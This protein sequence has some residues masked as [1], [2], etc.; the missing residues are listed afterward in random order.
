MTSIQV[1]AQCMLAK[2]VFSL[3]LMQR[4]EKPPISWKDYWAVSE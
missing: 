1:A 3:Q 4:T 2:L